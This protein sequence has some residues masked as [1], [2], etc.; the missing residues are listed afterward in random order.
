MV[1]QLQFARSDYTGAGRNIM[2]GVSGN[3]MNMR[4]RLLAVC[5]LVMLCPEVTVSQTEES[6]GQSSVLKEQNDTASPWSFGGYGEGLV[7]T[8]FFG[9]DPNEDYRPSEYRQTSVDLARI[10][11]FAGYEFSDWLSFESE[12]ELE[13]GGTGA[14]MELEWD[15]FGEYEMEVEKG[16]EIVLEQAFVEAALGEYVSV[17][18][19]HLLVPVG[20][21]SQ[22][23][24]P[25]LFS[26]THRPESESALI[27]STWH[28]TGVEV[29]A[30]YKGFSL[31][32]Q[33]V[34][35][36][37]ST[38]FSSTNW[39]A[40]GSQGRFE[41]T[42]ANDWGL[43]GRLDFSGVRGLLVGVS[44]Y[45]SN[46]T[47]NRPKRDMYDDA[48]RVYIG[49]I[50]LRYNYGP[51][52]ARAL[53]MLGKLNNADAVTTYNRRLSSH[54]GVPRTNVASAAYAYYLELALDTLALFKVTDRQRLDVF[55][56]YDGYDTMWKAPDPD[57]GYDDGTLQR[58][59]LTM[60]LNYFIHPRVVLK[61]EYLRRWINKDKSWNRK[62]NEI[63]FA[64]GFVL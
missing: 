17:K 25:N 13:H 24:T 64:L 42:S 61:G 8:Q 27:P 26:A 54:L 50:H 30:R 31:Q 40:G 21:I 7:T 15:E 34:T 20:M 19:G 38:G 32:L 56:R 29:A 18:L 10:V 2:I 28:E 37:D 4:L 36:L 22:Y 14:T 57:S 11:F 6:D 51:F 9:P 60:G 45:T 23:H 47:R 12:L 43:V 62:Q 35:G 48:A 33:A 41:L 16:G 59:V 63:N 46:T 52:R 44:G 55:L 58:Q 53:G 3:T 1:P 49:D 5:L 39:I